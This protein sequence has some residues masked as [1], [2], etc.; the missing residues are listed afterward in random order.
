MSEEPARGGRLWLA[1]IPVIAFLVLAAIFWRGLSGNPSEIPSALIG[2]P[3]PA[4]TLP[5]VEGLGIPGF[6]AASLK[7][8]QVTLVNVWASWSGPAGSNILY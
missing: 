1:A 2:K 3:V 5:P 8:G 7:A 6:D 4:F